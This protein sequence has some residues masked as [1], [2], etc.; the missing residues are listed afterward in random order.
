ML[1]GS[2]FAVPPPHFQ[3]PPPRLSFFFFFLFF[4]CMCMCVCFETKEHIEQGICTRAQKGAWAFVKRFDCTAHAEHN[5]QVI[6]RAWGTVYCSGTTQTQYNAI[7]QK[8]VPLK[9]KEN[10]SLQLV[11]FF[12][13]HFIETKEK[14]KLQT[15]SKQIENIYTVR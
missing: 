5:Q 7:R 2:R 12:F 6:Y 13:K 14:D 1:R 3:P 9:R 15:W 11:F 10:Y 8:K 4:V